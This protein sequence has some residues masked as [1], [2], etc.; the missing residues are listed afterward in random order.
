MVVNHPKP[1]LQDTDV[2]IV[3]NKLSEKFNQHSPELQLKHVFAGGLSGALTRAMFQP[4]DVL[5]IR[6]QL[7]VEPVA[8]LQKSKYKSML[9]AVCLVRKEEGVVGLWKGHN[10]AQA[11]SII[12]GVSQFW[13]YEELVANANNYKLCV[14]HAALTN[15]TCGGIAG[16]L[17][18]FFANP[19]DV[20]RTRLIA[21]DFS[22]GYNN[23]YQV[24]KIII[25]Q[26][27]I[28]GLYRGFIP[29]LF[30][31]VP[32][33]GSN[34]MLYKFFCGLWTNTMELSSERD[35]PGLG[36][37]CI[38]GLAG[39]ISKTILYP[40]DLAKKR[41]QIQGFAQYRKTFGTFFECTG[42]LHCM[43][44]T[45]KMEGFFGLYKGLYPSMWKAGVTTA[46]HFA[47]YDKICSL[48]I[49]EDEQ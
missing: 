47:F 35:I 42:L 19:L 32:M 6:F 3:K 7:Q 41:L 20:V 17:A 37:V 5:K 31:V 1:K 12:F 25:L 14:N 43:K 26:D 18:A 29:S 40:M 24:L 49:K 33:T 34:F 15:F 48:I 23:T 9:Q 13:C 27:G 36:L 45:I 28:K 21:Q 22:R 39:V 11:L 10:S 30:Q 38:G 46:F 8:K 44:Q 2:V 4:F 16:G